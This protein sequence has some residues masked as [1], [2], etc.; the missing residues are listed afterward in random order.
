MIDAII[1]LDETR[2]LAR[3]D[4]L[5]HELH[6]RLAGPIR[7]LTEALF[8]RVQ[9]AEPYRTGALR[10]ATRSFV[11]DRENLI[12]GRV[13]VLGES[14]RGKHNVKAGA[15]EYG[16]HGDAAVHGYAREDATVSAYHRDVNIAEHRFLRDAALDLRTEFEAMVER[17]IAEV[18][19]EFEA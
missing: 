5:P 9:A 17:A 10:A 7:E 4:H 13:R 8:A 1:S 16:A 15:L 19:G 12:R 14:G 3:L 6:A 11:D 2:L 18:V